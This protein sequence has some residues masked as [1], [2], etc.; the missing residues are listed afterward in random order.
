MADSRAEET[1]TQAVKLLRE[2]FS[3]RV[4]GAHNSAAGLQAP[5]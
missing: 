4:R 2:A 3:Q 1:F 5:P